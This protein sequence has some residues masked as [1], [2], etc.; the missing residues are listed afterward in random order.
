MLKK[1]WVKKAVLKKPWVKK[2]C[3]KNHG[4]KKL[5]WKNYGLKKLCWKNHGLKK[6][7]WTIR[8]LKKLCKKI[9]RA[10]KSVGYLVRARNQH[11]NRRKLQKKVPN[12]LKRGFTAPKSGLWPMLETR[13]AT[14][15]GR[16]GLGFSHFR[17]P[18]FSQV[19]LGHKI[20]GV[21]LFQASKFR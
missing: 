1:P 10:K 13:L 5:C 18:N 9:L 12:S 17:H 14:Q 15:T 6:L 7:C 21:K 2:L 8:G 4:L 20:F 11:T 16:F 3:W 19:G